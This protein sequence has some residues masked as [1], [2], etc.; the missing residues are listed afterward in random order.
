MAKEFSKHQQGIVKRYYEHHE[1]IQSNKLSE[2]VSELWLADTEKKKTK[3]WGKA[4]VALMRLGVDANEVAAAVGDR[5]LEALAALVAKVDA[6]T[7][8]KDDG[9]GESGGPKRVPQHDDTR[10]VKQMR[11]EKQ[12][13]GGYDSLDEANL[14]RA[15]N[16][17]KRK[18]KSIRRDDESRLGG[19]YTSAG[20]SSDITAIQPPNQFPAAVW[21]KLVEKGKLRRA[22]QGTYEVAK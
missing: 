12:A 2:L 4:Q 14:R 3:L 11:Q 15:M 16:A 22:G 10:T 20:R 17:F 13:E 1:T 6:G 19:R 5:D 18:L 21:N 9:S 8:P 7:A